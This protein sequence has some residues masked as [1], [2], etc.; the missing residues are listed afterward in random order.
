MIAA[1]R[2]GRSFLGSELD[3]KYYKKSIE[4]LETLTGEKT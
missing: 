2:T 4:R 3:E 1:K